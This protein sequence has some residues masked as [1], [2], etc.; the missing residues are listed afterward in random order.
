MEER[1]KCVN[2]GL[3]PGSIQL[4]AKWLCSCVL[5]VP[6]V[7]VCVFLPPIIVVH[8]LS[9]EKHYLATS[10]CFLSPFHQGRD[11]LWVTYI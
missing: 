11:K 10:Y 7:F 6:V 3:Q 2:E 5:C 1:S 8:V 4:W 9:E